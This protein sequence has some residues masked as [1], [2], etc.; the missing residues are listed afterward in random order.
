MKIFYLQ[1]KYETN[2]KVK[3]ANELYFGMSHISIIFVRTDK[4]SPAFY[5]VNIVFSVARKYQ[6]LLSSV[7]DE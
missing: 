2:S 3:T 7:V 6:F 4:I 1:I 5:N